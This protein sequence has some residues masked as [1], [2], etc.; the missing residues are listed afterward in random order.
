MRRSLFGRIALVVLLVWIGASAVIAIASVPLR[1]APRLN[2]GPRLAQRAVHY[3]TQLIGVP[4]DYET[5]ARIADELG[6][7][8]QIDG[9]DGSWMW[10]RQA[11]PRQT[12]FDRHRSAPRRLRPHAGHNRGPY[13]TISVTRAGYRFSY[14]LRAP[15]PPRTAVPLGY[16]LALGLALLALL[17]TIRRT[18]APLQHLEHAAAR[19]R[20][21]DLGHRVA[22][23][24]PREIERLGQSFNQMATRVQQM[25][26]DR[27]Q[28]LADVSH[29]LRSPIGRMRLGVEMLPAG[30][31]REQL[32]RELLEMQQLVTTLLDVSRLSSEA[33][34]RSFDRASV[35]LTALVQAE[36]DRHT[37]VSYRLASDSSAAV[38]VIGDATQLIVALRNLID[39][40]LRYNPPDAAPVRVELRRTTERIEVVVIDHGPG[41]SPQL[42]ERIFEPFVRGDYAR[43]R[44]DGGYGLGLALARRVA[45]AHGGDVIL[46]TDTPGATFVLWLPLP[47]D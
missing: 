43:A 28:L 25:V 15:A 33:P 44:N 46:A 39:N 5:A 10:P 19:I 41:V 38:T 17:L 36:V 24:G 2:P 34:Q 7:Q 3:F 42:R 32:E 16:G 1:R 6:L 47:V 14:R 27:E 30:S 9:P 11:L 29:E 20:D 31:R 26:A 22:P 37:A 13:Q 18:L 23:A 35:D 4:P 12:P 21:G 45:R 8:I 40:A